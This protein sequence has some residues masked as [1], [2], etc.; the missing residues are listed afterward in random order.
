MMRSPR[1]TAV[2]EV[3]PRVL[4]GADRVEQVERP[5]RRAAVQRAGQR[6]DAADDR[7]AEVGTGRHDHAGGERRRVE[8][9]VDRRDLVLL[10]RPRDVGVGLL[11]GEH[12]EVVGAVAEVVAR[13]DRLEALPCGGAAP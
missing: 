7:G 8:P 11:A 4:G 13:L 1:C 12:A 5:R 3:R 9:V 6:A 10:D 2:D